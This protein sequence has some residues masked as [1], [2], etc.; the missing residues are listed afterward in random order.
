MG[1]EDLRR[2]VNVLTAAIWNGKEINE[3]P[4]LRSTDGL[5]EAGDHQSIMEPISLFMNFSPAGLQ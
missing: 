1:L 2:M 4:A 3:R 5:A